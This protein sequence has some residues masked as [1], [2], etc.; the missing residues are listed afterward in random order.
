MLKLGFKHSARSLA[1]GT[2]NEQMTKTLMWQKS[3]YICIY[4]KELLLNHVNS[5]HKLKKNN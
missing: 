3:Y 4:K 1:N 2:I 5:F